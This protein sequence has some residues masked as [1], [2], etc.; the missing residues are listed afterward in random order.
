MLA[1][2]RVC[3]E[4]HREL[5]EARGEGSF[6]GLCPAGKGRIAPGE[7]EAYQ[8]AQRRIIA[9]GRCQVHKFRS[10]HGCS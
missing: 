2:G 8:L 6:F 3:G 5:I 1:I 9:P 7:A 4:G 10:D